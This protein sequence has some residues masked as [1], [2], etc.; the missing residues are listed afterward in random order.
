MDKSDR[1]E[2]TQTLL[3]CKTTSTDQMFSLSLNVDDYDG[4]VP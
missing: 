2:Y 1:F 3:S 4:T